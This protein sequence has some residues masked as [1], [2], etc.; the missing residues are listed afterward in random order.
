MLATYIVMKTMKKTYL[1]GLEGAL[2]GGAGPDAVHLP[3]QPGPLG[4]SPASL[5]RKK[6]RTHRT[7]YM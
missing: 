6:A 1:Q 2:F 4:P 3:T 7:I 5:E